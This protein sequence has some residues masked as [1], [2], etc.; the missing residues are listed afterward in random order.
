MNVAIA[1]AV[2]QKYPELEEEIVS[3][4]TKGYSENYVYGKDILKKYSYDD[5]LM[6]SKNPLLSKFYRGALF[7]I[8]LVSKERGF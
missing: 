4:F 5:N 8:I 7:K 1:G 3:N 2:L 6:I